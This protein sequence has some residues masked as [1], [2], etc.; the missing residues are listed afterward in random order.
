MHARTRTS[1]RKGDVLCA[2]RVHLYGVAQ[3]A[4]HVRMM[5]C[6]DVQTEPISSRGPEMKWDRHPNLHHRPH[7]PARDRGRLQVQ[8]RRAFAVHGP[9]VSSS[10]IYDW[11]YARRRL[12]LGK[13]LT[14]PHRYSVWRILMTIGDPIGRGAGSARP[15]LWRLRDTG[16]NEAK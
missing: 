13:P 2:V 16:E 7:A 8:I 9:V 1:L 15:I 5:C 10:S 14:L 6:A 4:Q 12:M 11:C 3:R